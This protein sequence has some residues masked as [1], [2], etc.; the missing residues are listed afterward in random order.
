M[1]DKEHILKANNMVHSRVNEITRKYG[2]VIEGF[3]HIYKTHDD[4]V[5]DA[6]EF[7]KCKTEKEGIEFLC[8]KY[9]DNVIETDDKK[10]VVTLGD[11]YGMARELCKTARHVNIMHLISI[12]AGGD[13]DTVYSVK[14]LHT[15]M[16]KRKTLIQTLV[17]GMIW[18]I[19][20]KLISGF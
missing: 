2:Y 15:S 18:K 7:L 9:K 8:N 4:A 11:A 20:R 12:G 17:F 1:G 14:D 5:N 13:D 10:K 19:N 3:S 16:I 6:L